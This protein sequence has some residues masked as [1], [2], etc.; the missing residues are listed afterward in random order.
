M[1]NFQHWK[2]AHSEAELA[3][4]PLVEHNLGKSS[5]NHWSCAEV[6]PGNRWGKPKR[7]SKEMQKK[8]T[9]KVTGKNWIVKQLKLCWMGL[10]GKA[11]NFEELTKQIGQKT[12][13]CST[14]RVSVHLTNPSFPI[15][16]TSYI[17]CPV[18]CIFSHFFCFR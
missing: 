14:K 4:F 18:G 15:N 9:L 10:S 13:F 16:I 6:Q 1:T 2:A 12:H 8:E 17:C 11:K 5:S 3:Q 7:E